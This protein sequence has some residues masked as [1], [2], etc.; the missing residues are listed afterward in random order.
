MGNGC[1]P[2]ALTVS[3]ITRF[4]D[5]DSKIELLSQKNIHSS[6][7]LQ[8]SVTLLKPVPR[9]VKNYCWVGKEPCGFRGLLSLLLEAFFFLVTC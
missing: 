8:G 4:G 5:L 1:L 2:E 7:M 3:S 6:R 9:Q